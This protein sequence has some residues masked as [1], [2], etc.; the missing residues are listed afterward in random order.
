MY[1]RVIIQTTASSTASWDG[2]RG[3]SISC[4]EGGSR[5]A[6]R[7]EGKRVGKRT[8]RVALRLA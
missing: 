7:E 1:M 3:E 4:G 2:N 6:R 5:A 8:G